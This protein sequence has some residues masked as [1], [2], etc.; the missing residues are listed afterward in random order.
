VE[1]ARDA[2]QLLLTRPPV[3]EFQ[4]FNDPGLF[5]KLDRAID[6]GDRNGVVLLDSTPIKLIHIG[7]IF[8]ITYNTNYDLS[9]A[10]HANAL[11]KASR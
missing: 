9:L 2:H 11:F 10:G 1:R 8:R 3:A 6:S 7:M 4:A 5:Q